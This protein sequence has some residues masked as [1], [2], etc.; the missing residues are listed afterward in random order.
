LAEN[1]DANSLV[2]PVGKA[3][4]DLTVRRLDVMGGVLHHGLQI[5]HVFEDLAVAA[6]AAVLRVETVFEVA[7]LAIEFVE[8]GVH[9]AR[10]VVRED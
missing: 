2:E 4:V 1:R 6:R 9:V 7:A 10:L 8:D 3:I 5:A